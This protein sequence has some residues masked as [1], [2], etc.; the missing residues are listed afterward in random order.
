MNIVLQRATTN[1][2]IALTLTEKTTIS[3]AYYLFVFESDQTKQSYY[4]IGNQTL[5]ST[6][7]NLFTITEGVS[8]PVNGSLILG[9][10]GF[11]KYTVYAQTSST[12]LNPDLA[13]EE[14]EVGKMKLISDYVP[15]FIQHEILTQYRVH[16]PQ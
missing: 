11:Y 3:N 16:E 6:R 14:V 2:K 4:V 1:E 13:D 8:D 9:H 15:R 5:N 12:N 10:D 7:I